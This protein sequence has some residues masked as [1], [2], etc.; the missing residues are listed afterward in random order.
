MN[1]YLLFVYAHT[2]ILVT[3]GLGYIGSITTAVLLE[4]GYTVHIIDNLINSSID[5]LHTLMTLYSNHTLAFTNG[6]IRSRSTLERIFQNDTITH[7]LHFAGLKAVGESVADPLRYYDTNVCGTLTLLQ[8]MAAHNV[9]NLVFSSSATV[10]GTPQNLPLHET[11]RSTLA[12]ITNPYGATKRIIEHMLQDLAKSDSVWHITSLRYFNPVGTHPSGK[13]GESPRGTPNNLMPY[14][15]QV[16][17]GQR[18]TLQVFGDDYDTPDGTGVRDYIHVMDLAEGHLVALKHLKS[19]HQTVNLGTGKGYSVLEVVRTFEKVTGAKVPCRVVARRPGD[20]ACC[21]AD[22]SLAKTLW[23]WG[24]TRDLTS[25][26]RDAWHFTC[27]N[28]AL[29]KVECILTYRQ[30][31]QEWRIIQID[32]K[33]ITEE[34]FLHR[35]FAQCDPKRVHTLMKISA[36]FL[37]SK[38]NRELWEFGARDGKWYF[39]SD[40]NSDEETYRCAAILQ[41]WLTDHCS[42]A[43]TQTEETKRSM[44]T[45]KRSSRPWQCEQCQQWFVIN[46][47]TRQCPCCDNLTSTE[48]Y[49]ITASE[50]ELDQKPYVAPEWQAPSKRKWRIAKIYAIGSNKQ[51]KRYNLLLQHRLRLVFISDTHERHDDVDIPNCDILIHTGDMTRYG[52]AHVLKDVDAWFGSLLKD[53]I[54]RKRILVVPGNHDVSLHSE[55]AERFWWRYSDNPEQHHAVTFQH[56]TVLRDEAC[57]I[58]GLRFYGMP[59]CVDYHGWAFM[60][61]D[62]ASKCARIPNHV[63]ILLTHHPPAGKLDTMR[64]CPDLAARIKIVKP[65]LCAFGH[66]HSGYGVLRSSPTTYLNAAIEG[67]RSPIVVDLE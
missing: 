34:V 30:G 54:V 29:R 21:Y 19:G 56:A 65:L 47:R 58:D 17:L 49:T 13:L 60:T 6:D 9:T 3:G 61:R 50:L 37:T 57:E 23:G 39:A 28:N 15:V 33:C 67:K 24:A 55:F 8:V 31:G 46:P 45:P 10:Y 14:V 63:D 35:V 22:A 48:K 51:R 38:N 42:K 4:A 16:A 62:M 12:E 41:S 52:D 36:C 53:G 40:W 18:P 7:V 25:M 26:C 44:A 2:M 66:I 20:I 5:V 59:W 11:D 64:G 1:K 43:L 27:K 32:P